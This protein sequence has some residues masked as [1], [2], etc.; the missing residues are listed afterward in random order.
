PV[1]PSVFALVGVTPALGRFF[2]EADAR[3]NSDAVVVLSDRL[4]RE[5]FDSD[6]GAVGRSVVVDGR[7]RTIV[8][9]APAGFEFPI[10]ETGTADHNTLL[11]T[12]YAVAA[13]AKDAVA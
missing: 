13:P 3:P 6:P 7:P 2:T 10:F 12:P 4:W 1:T 5:R 8:G 9:V 11:W